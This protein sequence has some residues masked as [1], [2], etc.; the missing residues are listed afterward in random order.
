MVKE[1][2]HRQ[3]VKR[4]VYSWPSLVAVA[5]L[6]FFLVKG[7]AGIMGIERDSAERVE[8]LEDQSAA[9]ILR[10]NNLK[11]E[12]ESLKTEEGIVGAIKDKFSATREGEYVAIIVDE[13]SKAAATVAVEPSWYKKFWNAIIGQ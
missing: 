5:L 8:A 10:E 1:L 6:T 13:R 12:I 11:A 4:V 7:A 3:K 2:E 9:L